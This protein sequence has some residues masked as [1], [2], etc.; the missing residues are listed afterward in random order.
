MFVWTSHE[1]SI[2]RSPALEYG[3]FALSR[4][5]TYLKTLCIGMVLTSKECL[6]ETASVKVID[7]ASTTKVSNITEN[8][9]AVGFDLNCSFTTRV[10]TN[11][12]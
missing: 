1:T 11:I 10:S 3:N 7:I 9:L 4:S 5:P 6:G 12:A 8:G 2:H